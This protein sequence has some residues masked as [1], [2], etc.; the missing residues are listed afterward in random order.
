MSTTA[1]TFPPSDRLGG[2]QVKQCLAPQG[3]QNRSGGEVG[4][5][6]PDDIEK[7]WCEYLRYQQGRLADAGLEYPYCYIYPDE[8]GVAGSLVD[9]IC[10]PEKHEAKSLHL[11]VTGYI[12]KL[13]IQQLEA[14][15]AKLRGDTKA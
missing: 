2:D 11:A 12:K 6:F 1:K 14:E 7:T 10:L 13:K 3:D 8:E 9:N 4:N 5:Q 15:L